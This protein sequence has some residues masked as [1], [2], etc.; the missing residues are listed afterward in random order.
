MTRQSILSKTLPDIWNNS[1]GDFLL[2]LQVLRADVL[3]IDDDLFLENGHYY[4][5]R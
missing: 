4:N 5:G 3:A 2:V 1:V